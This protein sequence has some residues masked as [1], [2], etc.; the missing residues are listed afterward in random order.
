MGHH[1]VV[2][3]IAVGFAVGV[4]AAG[5]AGALH[6]VCAG[7]GLGERRGGIEG[8]GVVVELAVEGVYGGGFFD[9]VLK[10]VGCIGVFGGGLEKAM[11]VVGDLPRK[12]G[13]DRAD[14]VAEGL[15]G[16]HALAEG[17]LFFHAFYTEQ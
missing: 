10:L 1:G 6:N 9:A 3:P 17:L 2:L 14:I 12:A 16:L 4:V 5:G 15:H 7:F 8:C 13:I 11:G